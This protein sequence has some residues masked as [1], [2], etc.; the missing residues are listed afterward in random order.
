MSATEAIARLLGEH[1]KQIV[2]DCLAGT[3][4]LLGDFRRPKLP[5]CNADNPL[6][7]KAEL[8]LVRES[9]TYGHLGQTEALPSAQEMLRP[10]N[11]PCDNE[12]VR[13]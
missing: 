1:A 10:F 13:W 8:A 2:S 11:A 6:E 12:L 4:S 5:R 7:V 3:R 9:G